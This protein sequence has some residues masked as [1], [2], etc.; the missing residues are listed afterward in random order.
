MYSSWS[1]HSSGLHLISNRIQILNSHFKPPTKPGAKKMASLFQQ[2]V[3][4]KVSKVMIRFFTKRSRARIQAS[5]SDWKRSS[6]FKAENGTIWNL[7]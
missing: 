7:H 1:L 5:C 6:D 3:H 2:T 4:L